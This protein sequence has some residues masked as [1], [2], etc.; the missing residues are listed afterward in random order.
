M[1]EINTF[2][3]KILLNMITAIVILLALA[4]TIVFWFPGYISFGSKVYGVNTPNKTTMSIIT[5][6]IFILGVT[7]ATN[8]ITRNSLQHFLIILSFAII[9]GHIIMAIIF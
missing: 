4:I 6:F 8:K 1:N 2:P 5:M 7:G 9:L 3:K